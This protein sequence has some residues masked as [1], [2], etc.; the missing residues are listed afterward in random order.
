M[1]GATA[2]LLPYLDGVLVRG[3]G[4]AEMNEEAV[5]EAETETRDAKERPKHHAHMQIYILILTSNIC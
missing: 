3:N 2:V 1:G 5:P 4:A